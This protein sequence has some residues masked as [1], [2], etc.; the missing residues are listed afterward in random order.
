[1]HA[2]GKFPVPLENVYRGEVQE[3]NIDLQ[4][5][6]ILIHTQRGNDPLLITGS[7]QVIN[8]FVYANCRYWLFECL[9]TLPVTSLG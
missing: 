7:A 9:V 5:I 6:Y 2:I 8:V 3:T 4:G 1:M